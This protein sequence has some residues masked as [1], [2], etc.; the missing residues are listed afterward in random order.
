MTPSGKRTCER[1]GVSWFDFSGNAHIVGPKLRVIIEGQPNRFRKRGRPASLFAAKSSR[2]ARLLLMA[3][4]RVWTQREIAQEAGISEGL[5]SRVVARLEE[6]RYVARTDT[7][8]LSMMKPELLFE[9]W[10]DEYEFSRHHVIPGHVAA[11]SGDALTRFVA[12]SLRH[13]GAE[14]AATGLAAAWQLTHFASFRIATF[15]LR[16]EP[17]PDIRELLELRQDD[18]GANLWLVVPNDEGVF[19]GAMDRDGVQCAHPVQ[20]YLDLDSHPE[21]A[22]EAAERVRAQHLPW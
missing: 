4:T 13:A 12:D 10:R 18:R 20:V 22:R 21:R 14:Y 5:V 15:Y 2:I 17:T 6:D 9:A 3:P 1:A 11:R 19:Q 8:G 16:A 7:G